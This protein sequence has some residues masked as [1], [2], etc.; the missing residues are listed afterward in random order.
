MNWKRKI[1]IEAYKIALKDVIPFFKVG[2]IK[3]VDIEGYIKKVENDDLQN[4]IVLAIRKAINMTE[5]YLKK[6]QFW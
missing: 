5:E 1:E 6:D 4:H 2:I 3:D